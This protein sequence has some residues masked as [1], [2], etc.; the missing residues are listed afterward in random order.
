MV[1]D[2]VERMMKEVRACRAEGFVRKGTSIWCGHSTS[3]AINCRRGGDCLWNA[4]RTISTSRIRQPRKQRRRVLLGLGSSTHQRETDDQP[5]SILENLSIARALP[6]WRWWKS[7]LGSGL[8][9]GWTV[10]AARQLVWRTPS[11]RIAGVLEHLY[12]PR[13]FQLLTVKEAPL[14]QFA[15]GRGCTF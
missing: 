15:K 10:I 9:I 3:T 11:L 12:C 14:L 2:D 4:G 8:S 13:C 7:R 5:V 6:I 1:E